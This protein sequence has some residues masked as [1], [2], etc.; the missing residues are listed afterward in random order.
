MSNRVSNRDALLAG[1]SGA[2]ARRRAVALELI[3]AALAAIEPRRV[4]ILA[5][6]RARR[7]GARLDGCTVF[8]FGKA[9]RGM[10]EGALAACEVRGGLVVSYDDRGALGPLALRRG[11][12]PLPLPDAA[13]VGREVL[14]LAERLGPDEVALCLVSGG[15]STML[16]LPREGVTLDEIARVT[17]RLGRA[18]APIEELNHA[19]S[20]L[21]R[22]K[23]GGLA[24]ALAPARIVNVVISDVPGAG[25]ELVA[26]GPTFAPELA[27]TTTTLV[28][29]DNLTARRA[30]VE[31]ARARGL[32]LEDTP[33]YFRG[34][35]REAAPAWLGACRARAD[36]AERDGFV[37][38]G[39]TTVTVRGAGRGGRC[40]E[41]ALGVLARGYAEAGLFVALGT[42]GVDGSSAAAGALVD[43]AVGE[44]VRA[45]GLEPRAALD[46]S[47]SDA[48]FRAARS[49]VVTGRTGTNV[50]DLWLY[51]RG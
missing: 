43:R 19:R 17:A 10:A 11:G 38:G 7:A 16:E 40:Q 47:D 22:L 15:G 12:H 8:A 2:D 51:L 28:A 26:S 36:H 1:A 31:A 29:A 50:A 18:G 5:L 13:E 46:E 37:W 20:A 24:R 25:P 27:A 42:D 9:A 35:S 44:R 4:T 3:D 30:L 14:A 45:C 39:E 21:S 32:V 49:R 34:E 23:A 33:S 6:E 41:A 48:F